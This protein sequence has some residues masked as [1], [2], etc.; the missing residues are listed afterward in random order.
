MKAFSKILFVTTLILTFSCGDA[1]EP[2]PVSF[3]TGD[4]FFSNDAELENG[5]LAM[6]E[7]LQGTNTPQFNEPRATQIEF[8]LTE[9]RSDNTQSRNGG[10]L[11]SDF[12]QF[13]LYEVDVQN[14]VVR[15]YYESMYNI[16][17]RAHLVLD[18]I[19]NASDRR[20]EEFEGQ[21][22][23]VRAYSYFQLVRLF[24]PVP[25]PLRV[26]APEEAEIA[27]TRVDAPMVYQQIVQDLK[28]AIDNLDDSGSRTMA[29]RSAAQALLAKVYLTIAGAE[30]I[31]PIAN[32]DSARILCEDIINSGQF[33]LMDNYFDVFNS[34]V[35]GR[36]DPDDEELAPN[37][38]V[39]FAI[40]YVRNNPLTSQNYSREWG[41]FGFRFANFTTEDIRN[42]YF[43]RGETERVAFAESNSPG[44]FFV[45]KYLPNSSILEQAG[46]DWIVLRYADVLLMYAESILSINTSTGDLR[47]VDAYNE[48]RERAGFDVP[49]FA[50]TEDELFEERRIELAFENQRFFDLLRID[51]NQNSAELILSTH[52]VEVGGNFARTDLLLPIPQNEINLSLGTST[53][54]EQNNG[55]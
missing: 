19:E 47:A 51:E 53:I 17:F 50:F 27:F 32:Y 25:M 34:E 42:A 39:I 5:V 1:L 38:E 30:N 36:E 20:R 31:E 10:S 3:V 23:F 18:N 13:E 8:Y 2:E 37:T 29:T 41:D 28:A 35:N 48:V 49:A 45:T 22:R 15:N 55:Y 21:A 24:G 40:E 6:Y 14:F 52:S 44:A 12:Q 43:E 4:S 54:L 7:G 11:D 16:I 26:I 46:N 33:A 9:M